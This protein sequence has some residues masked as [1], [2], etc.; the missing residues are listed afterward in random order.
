MTERLIGKLSHVVLAVKDLKK[1]E[2]FFSKLFDMP[3]THM[4][5]LPGVGF[6]TILC[7]NRLEIISPTRPDSDVARFIEKKGEGI[8]AVAFRTSDAGKARAKAES[9]GVRVAGDINQ[10]DLA[11][12]QHGE[13]REIWIHPKD[14]FGLYL[15][16]A[17][18]HDSESPA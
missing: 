18:Y 3:F 12:D 10:D 15:M 7:E 9:M 1:A 2:G 13:F 14:A 17:Q 5:E 4:G 11:G 8:Y 16:F 6:E